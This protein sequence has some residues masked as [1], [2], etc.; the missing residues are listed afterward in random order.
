MLHE[1]FIP[2]FNTNSLQQ[3][4]GP[5]LQGL[6]RRRWPLTPALRSSLSLFSGV[7]PFMMITENLKDGSAKMSYFK[8]ALQK[9]LA[10]V[11]MK[12]KTGSLMWTTAPWW[13]RFLTGQRPYHLILAHSWGTSV[14]SFWR[15]T[16][17]STAGLGKLSSPVGTSP[18]AWA[19]SQ[20]TF[21]GF[22]WDGGVRKSLILV[23]HQVCDLSLL[24][25]PPVLVSQGLGQGAF[26]SKM[27]YKL[28]L[29]LL[30]ELSPKVTSVLQRSYVAVR[31]KGNSG[32][33]SAEMTRFG[34]TLQESDGHRA[35][36]FWPQES[37]D[38][39]HLVF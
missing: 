20:D 6:R 33:S 10:G 25:L 1:D 35:A 18:K 21:S 38:F 13:G 23:P 19:E 37:A 7:C 17:G 24:L 36:A 39:R 22:T 5:R 2:I 32:A 16:V 30:R 4:W 14:N 3:R 31:D 27:I 26:F 15:D 34:K 9:M 28:S 8:K 11:F 12:F 29:P